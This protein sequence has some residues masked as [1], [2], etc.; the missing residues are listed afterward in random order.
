MESYIYDPF[1]Q[2][3]EHACE[4][5]PKFGGGTIS[6]S[7]FADEYRKLKTSMSFDV[8][9]NIAYLIEM[10]ILCVGLEADGNILVIAK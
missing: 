10:K 9:Q 6:G 2:A 7:V 1:F 4:I 5:L 8:Q 3:H